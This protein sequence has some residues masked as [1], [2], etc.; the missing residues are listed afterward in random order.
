MFI[1]KKEIREDDFKGFSELL[2]KL[3][4]RIEKIMSKEKTE[5]KIYKTNKF[6]RPRFYPDCEISHGVANLLRQKTFTRENLEDLSKI[7][8]KVVIHGG[9][10]EVLK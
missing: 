2:K 8:Y 7:G 6:G 5:I 3:E 9:D 4:K 1:K 10:V